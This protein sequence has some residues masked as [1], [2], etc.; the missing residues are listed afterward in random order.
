M[1]INGERWDKDLDKLSYIDQVLVQM[2]MN[3]KG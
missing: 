1:H 3:R 2:Y